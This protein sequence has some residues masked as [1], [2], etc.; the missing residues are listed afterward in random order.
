MELI[1]IRENIV[2]HKGFDVFYINLG[3]GF[4]KIK[5]TKRLYKQLAKLV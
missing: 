3:L 4:H 5:P 2:Y 1:T